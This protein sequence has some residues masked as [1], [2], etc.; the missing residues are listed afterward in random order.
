MQRLALLLLPF[1]L[2][3]C[4][5][6]EQGV[7]DANTSQP[8]Q[9]AP[10]IDNTEIMEAYKNKQSN[11]WVEGNGEVIKLLKDDTYGSRH[12]RFLV[13]LS[14]REKQTLLFAHN[15]D[16]APRINALQVGDTISFKGEYEYNPKGGI[17]HWTHHDPEGIAP[18]GWI[19]HEGKTY[20]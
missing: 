7:A 12:Q 6:T 10:A 18:G 1:L 4:F 5:Q 9:L 20:E 15:I 11:I 13:K 14:A 16:L 17:V 19:K 8:S 3:T 2:A